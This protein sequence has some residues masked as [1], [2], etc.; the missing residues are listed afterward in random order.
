MAQESSGALY[1]EQLDDDELY[2][3]LMDRFR[4]SPGVDADWIELSVSDG[5]VTLEG[6]LGAYSEVEVAE[7]IVDDVVGVESYAN[8]L[9]VDELHREQAPEAAD[10]A[11]AADRARDD[12]LGE[13]DAQQTDTAEHLVADLEEETYGTHDPQTAVRD[14]TPYI[15]PDGPFPEGYDSGETH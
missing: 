13:P 10:D 11:V 3:I 6:R 9:V 12:S 4:S 7:K 1:P 15:P 14:G 5:F 8:N 2:Q